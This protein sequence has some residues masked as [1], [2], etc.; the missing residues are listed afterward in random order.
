MSQILCLSMIGAVIG[1]YL[2]KY[3]GWAIRAWPSH[4][5][6]HCDY[7]KCPSCKKG[8]EFG[9]CNAGIAQ[10]RF[11]IA[12][13][14]IVAGVSVFFFG[15]S[16][17]ALI[18]WIFV[19]ACLIVTIV[20]IRCFI[21]PDCLSKG[22]IAAGLIYAA[23]AW[24]VLKW[25]GFQ[26]SYYVPFTDSFIGFVVG[27]GFLMFLGK[28]SEVVFKKPDGMGGGDVKLLA[29]M[30]AWAGW[31]PVIVTVLIASF[32]GASFGLATIIYDSIK[33]KKAYRPMSHHIPFGPYLCLGF[34]I[35]FYLGM[36]PF[37]N[38]FNAYQ[39]WIMNR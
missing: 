23:I 10:E 33:N 26:L 35:T 30:G 25:G 12:L 19:A 39:Y 11:Y 4:E 37:L 21:I 1:A 38:F 18:S 9:C 13:S 8:L 29:A 24:A 15:F 28:I 2:G 31:K 5:K 20:D 16:I 14:A 22:G 36:E 7:L 6:F 27:G 3:I 34:L 32:V 17:K